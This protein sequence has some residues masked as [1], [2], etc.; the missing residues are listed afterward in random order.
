MIVLD[1]G[2]DCNV[3]KSGNLKKIFALL[4]H[5][6]LLRSQAAG[7]GG[8]WD[9]RWLGGVDHRDSGSLCRE[10]GEVLSLRLDS[11]NTLCERLGLNHGLGADIDLGDSHGFCV[12]CHSAELV[13]DDSRRIR[14]FDSAGICDGTL[15]NFSAGLGHCTGCLCNGHALFDG[16]GQRCL[17]STSTTCLG[18]GVLW[19]GMMMVVMTMMMPMV[20]PV[21]MIVMMMMLVLVVLVEVIQRKSALTIDITRDSSSRDLRAR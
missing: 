3:V 10:L 6:L 20:I 1:Q 18:V 4:N 2:V 11:V 14:N 15:V 5:M 8:L 13:L 17:A 9:A 16:L 7:L 19:L 21:V 12:G